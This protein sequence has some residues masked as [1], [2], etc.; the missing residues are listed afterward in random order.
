MECPFDILQLPKWA[1]LEEIDKQWKTLVRKV[2][3]DK[4]GAAAGTEKTKTLNDARERAKLMYNEFD[5]AWARRLKEMEAESEANKKADE[6]REHKRKI[7]KLVREIYEN[8]YDK[9]TSYYSGSDYFSR[10]MR[11]WPPADK[12]EAEDIVQNG[13]G[14]SKTKLKEAERRMTQMQQAAQQATTDNE[15]KVRDLQSQLRFAKQHHTEMAERMAS[16]SIRANDAEKKVEELK[17]K[18]RE[19]DALLAT[20]TARANEAEQKVNEMAER[21]ANER[22]TLAGKVLEAQQ[23]PEDEEPHAEEGVTTHRKR[24]SCSGGGDR[25]SKTIKNFLT[26]HI[27]AADAND[28][29]STH[30]MMAAFKEKMDVDTSVTT[31]SMELSKQMSNAFPFAGHQRKGGFRG[32][33]GITLTD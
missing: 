15:H 22:A 12:E 9:T 11:D 25:L 14:N 32:Y 20:E 21:L 28:R 4:I 6:V 5:C 3:P 10:K 31:F 19:T 23:P 17:R 8:E 18:A 26:N 24:K 30:E 13:L 33:C 27:V 1:S 29:V 16:E 7:L 2:H